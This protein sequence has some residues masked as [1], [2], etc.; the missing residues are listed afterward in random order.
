MKTFER[1]NRV[2]APCL[3]VGR[4]PGDIA[5]SYATVSLAKAVLDWEA[6]RDIEEM[7]RDAWRWQS[8]NPHGYA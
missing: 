7:C 1:V 8:R 4:R 2:K 6:K 5:I 3:M